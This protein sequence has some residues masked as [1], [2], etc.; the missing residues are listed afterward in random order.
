[1]KIAFVNRFFFPLGGAEI[2]MFNEIEHLIKQSHE[3][4]VFSVNDER[5]YNALSSG[6]FI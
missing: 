6:F 3:I 4:A 2:V 1:M 5:N